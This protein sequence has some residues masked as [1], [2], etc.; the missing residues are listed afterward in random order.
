MTPLVARKLLA[1]VRRQE[2]AP[3]PGA[4]AEALG[5]TAREREVLGL[6]V[7]DLS[8]EAVAERLFVSPHTVRSHVKALRAKLGARTQL[9]AVAMLR[10]VYDEG[11]GAGLV[12]RPRQVSDDRAI[13]VPR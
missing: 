10:E 13:R 12:P 4:A 2:A 7:E 9:E 8:E 5:L 6:L 11:V 1:H 3:K